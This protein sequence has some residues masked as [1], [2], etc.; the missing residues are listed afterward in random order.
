MWTLREDMPLEGE[1]D[2]GASPSISMD[3]NFQWR[4]HC[5]HMESMC[6]VGGGHATHTHTHVH[7]YTHTHRR[8]MGDVD[9]GLQP[10]SRMEG[11]VE[12]GTGVRVS[13]CLFSDFSF[14][15]IFFCRGFAVVA[16]TGRCLS[17][18]ECGGGQAFFGGCWTGG[19]RSG[20]SRCVNFSPAWLY[21]GGVVRFMHACS[22]SCRRAQT[23]AS[24]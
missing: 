5:V 17:C 9:R 23:C 14:S 8:R 2:G 21:L 19:V 10:A 13:E 18:A 16:T 12:A 4:E 20:Q 15:S 22:C 3:G 11:E 6:I 7:T 1:G 24:M